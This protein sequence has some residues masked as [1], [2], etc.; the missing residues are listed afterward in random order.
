MGRGDEE[1]REGK[2]RDG[3]GKGKGDRGNWRDGT[4]HGMGRGG[5]GKERRK[6][7]ESEERGY[8]PQTSILAPPLTLESVQCCHL[9]SEGELML[10]LNGSLSL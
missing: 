3:G 2:G 1:G 6:G 8:S 5:K 4:G 7:R 10:R 9:A